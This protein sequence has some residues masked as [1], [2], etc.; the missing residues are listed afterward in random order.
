[1][2][3]EPTPLDQILYT[4]NDAGQFKASV[5]AA[6]DG[7]SIATVHSGYNS[8]TTAAMVALLQKVAREAQGELGMAKVDEVTIRDRDCTRLVCRYLSVEGE[9][10]ILAVVVPSGHPYRHVTNRAIR[11][12]RQLLS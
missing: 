7:L 10:L 3:T 11:Q 12:I 8:D 2:A 6:T 4:L 5:L 9:G 1:M